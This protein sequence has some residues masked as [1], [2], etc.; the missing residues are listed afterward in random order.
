MNTRDY[1]EKG[2]Y[3]LPPEGRYTLAVADF[4]RKVA[5]SGNPMLTVELVIRGGDFDG[6]KIWDNCVLIQSSFWRLASLCHALGFSGDID[7]NDNKV[8]W[9]LFSSGDME[10]MVEHEE[11]RDGVV[12]PKIKY[13]IDHPSLND[14][15]G[16]EPRD[17]VDDI[18]GPGPH[19]DYGPG[20]LDNAPPHE[21]SDAFGVDPNEDDCPY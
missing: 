10:A 7:E 20:N 2:N 18:A 6:S 17:T 3:P 12:R 14:E 11:G 4:E 5:K 15:G 19:G 21:D 9:G 1:K 8:M 13:Y 16:N